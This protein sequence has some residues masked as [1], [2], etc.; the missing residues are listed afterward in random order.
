MNNVAAN[1]EQSSPSNPDDP[2][3]PTTNQ[4]IRD[5]SI[6]ENQ[7]DDQEQDSNDNQQ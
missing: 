2:S 6:H 4:Q 7:G 3:S 1:T 5:S